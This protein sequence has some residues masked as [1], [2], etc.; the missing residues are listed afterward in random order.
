M[1]TEQHLREA[2]IE[3]DEAEAA[4]KWKRRIVDAYLRQLAN[5]RGVSFM[6]IEAAR[7]ELLE[8]SNAA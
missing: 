1:T 3:L 4:A 8:A 6:R 2:L 7:R 5:E